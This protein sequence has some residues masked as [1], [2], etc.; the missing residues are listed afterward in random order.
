VYGAGGVTIAAV[1]TQTVV[2]KETSGV[3]SVT[4]KAKVTAFAGGVTTE[5]VD[6]IT[7]SHT[8]ALSDVVLLV[9]VVT[10]AGDVWI[11]LPAATT[12]AGMHL[13]VKITKG[14]IRYGVVLQPNGADQIDGAAYKVLPIAVA[15]AGEAAHLFCCG[16][17]W[18]ILTYYDDTL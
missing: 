8:V 14:D 4:V 9:D 6:V 1:A 2:L 15:G 12:A 11:Y 17:A 7:T 18:W 13:W 5:H 10:A 3:A 16:V